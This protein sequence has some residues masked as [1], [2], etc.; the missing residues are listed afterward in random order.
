MSFRTRIR[1]RQNQ[2]KRSRPNRLNRQR[3]PKITMKTNKIRVKPMDKRK[4]SLAGS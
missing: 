1:G 3:T 4:K 2:R